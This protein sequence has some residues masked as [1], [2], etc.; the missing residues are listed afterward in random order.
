MTRFNSIITSLL[1]AIFLFSGC[2]DD[3]INNDNNK[4]DQIVSISL[5]FSPTQ[6]QSESRASTSNYGTDAERTIKT[7]FIAF[8]PCSDTYVVDDNALP[9]YAS[10]ETLSTASVLSDNTSG[11]INRNILFKN[12]LTKYKLCVIANYTITSPATVTYSNLK[13]ILNDATTIRNNFANANGTCATEVNCDLNTNR[14]LSS[15]LIRSA[16]RLD[17]QLAPKAGSNIISLKVVEMTLHNEENN[18]YHF[19]EHPT[20][21]SNRVDFKIPATE[22]AKITATPSTGSSTWAN[23]SIYSTPT[24]STIATKGA[25]WYSMAVEYTF[26]GGTKV[27][28]NYPRLLINDGAELIR[29]NIY[30]LIL[31]AN[32]TD[33]S[34]KT[35]VIPWNNIISS[36]TN[37]IGLQ[38]TSFDKATKVCNVKASHGVSPF[39]FEW[40]INDDLRST[41]AGNSLGES[42]FTI[43]PE[44]YT[45]INNCT[46]KCVV[47][48]AT[49][50]KSSISY[51]AG[52]LRMTMTD[53]RT[54]DTQLPYMQSWN[55][56]KADIEIAS[57][58]ASANRVRYLRDKRDNQVYRVKKMASNAWWMIQNLNYKP[59]TVQS[60]LLETILDYAPYRQ[61][62]WPDKVTTTY[63]AYSVIFQV[64]PTTK[65]PDIPEKAQGLCPNGWHIPAE[66][67]YQKIY[68]NID[69]HATSPA[70]IPDIDGYD[71]TNPKHFEQENGRGCYFGILTNGVDFFNGY[72][73]SAWTSTTK[74]E[75]KGTSYESLFKYMIYGTTAGTMGVYTGFKGT[76]QGNSEGLLF[77]VRCV[78]DDVTIIL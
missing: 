63:Y 48:D 26:T 47:T 49:G 23:A 45:D 71:D 13:A 74:T 10:F 36:E 1:F 33:I 46:L 59:G 3:S 42:S 68:P 5:A 20:L 51:N 77:T 60:D 57:E 32:G 12:P 8:Y 64:P 4:T 73:H 25:V 37:T 50:N 39:S 30:R 69:I 56:N 52:L 35:T 31:T 53:D 17:I 70:A 27:L 21:T 40:Y 78:K 28:Q 24:E 18:T 44:I 22:L 72:A 7:L 75:Y 11:H 58:G 9:I 16:I 29:N 65:A 43:E 15:E 41:N 76:N 2:S 67:D 14:N 61:R 66:S 62:S 55:S 19:L 6:A 54:P 34:I 38:F